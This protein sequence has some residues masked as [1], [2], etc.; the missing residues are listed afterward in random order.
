[1]A[2]GSGTGTPASTPAATTAQALVD[3]A[4]VMLSDPTDAEFSDSELLA[5]LNEAIQEYS[6]HV[7]RPS[8]INITTLANT[9]TYNLPYD[10]NAVTGV[11]YPA[12]QTPPEYLTRLRKTEHLSYTGRP[13]RD[14]YDRTYDVVNQNDLTTYPSLVLSFDPDAGKT[15][16]VYY[17][18]PHPSNLIASDYCTVIAEHQHILVH[19]VQYAAV[20]TQMNRE[21]A[22]P[23]SSSSLLMAQFASNLRRL[24]ISYLNALNRA[25]LAR[26]GRSRSARWHMDN[27]DRIY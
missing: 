18:H 7:P 2:T 20:R 21:Q 14:F 3:R 13:S 24:E 12:G 27:Y 25:L 17:T 8:S 19:Y 15:I 11:E 23:T 4:R 9:R 5:F 16:T 26:A 10:T 1:M 6:Q 22:N